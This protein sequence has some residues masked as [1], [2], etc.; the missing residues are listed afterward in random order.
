MSIPGGSN[1]LLLASA[2]GGGGYEISRSLRFNSSDSDLGGRKKVAPMP[3][4]AELKATLEYNPETGIFTR[5][6]TTSPNALKGSVAGYR[7]HRGYLRVSVCGYKYLGHR[8][9]WY[10]MTG[11]DPGEME[12]DH[13]NRDTTDNRFCNLRLISQQGNSIN[14]S[15]RRHNTSGVRGV[16]WDK[17]MNKWGAQIKNQGKKIHLGYHV[18]LEDA[19]CVY[20]KAALEIHGEYAVT[21]AMLQEVA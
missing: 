3:D 15:M 7:A 4:L 17:Q 18:E 9:A 5:L 10:Y 12:V 21:N 16:Y 8:L 11:E 1:P 6:K 19:K 13:I 2:A 20:D 14:C